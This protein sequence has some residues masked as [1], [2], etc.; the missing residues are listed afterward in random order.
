MSDRNEK[1]LVLKEIIEL[2]IEFNNIQIESIRKDSTDK[3][4]AILIN[5]YEVKNSTLTD[6]LTNI[7]DLL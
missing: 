4:Q 5:L 3:Y 1:L 6:V 2:D 7:N